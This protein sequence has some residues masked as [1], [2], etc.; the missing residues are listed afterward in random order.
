MVT[1]KSE[2]NVFFDVDGTL[3]VN[4]GE[5]AGRLISVL[6]PVT[7]NYIL[8]EA[9]EPNIRLLLE[10]SHRGS[11]VVVWSR[12][13]YEWASNV[14][15]ALNLTNKVQLVMT[16]PFVYFDDIPVEQ[17]LTNRVFLNANDT[18]K[19]KQKGAK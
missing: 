13:G 2:Q 7:D 8:M 15:K 10:E 16:K 19:T 14:L 17:W 3:I 4:P 1:I 11:Y 12:G 6:D 5:G 9:H 18:Y